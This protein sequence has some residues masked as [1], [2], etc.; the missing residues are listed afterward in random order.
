ML[1]KPP[2]PW[3]PRLAHR[4]PA[5]LLA[6]LCVLGLISFLSHRVPVQFAHYDAG[7]PDSY[8]LYDVQ[9][10]VQTG[11]I[12]RDMTKPPHQPSLYSPLLYMM[13]GLPAR[14]WAFENPFAGPRI[15]VWIALALCIWVCAG[16]AHR[17]VR[18]RAVGW[19]AAGLAFIS[20]IMYVWAGQLRGDFPGILAGLV[21]V[22][23]L[24][25]R[26][27]F[28]VAA[29]GLCAGLATQAKLT[30]VAALGAGLLW[31]ALRRKWRDVVTF[32][33]AGAVG[34][35]GVYGAF[36][37]LEPRMLEHILTLG[38]PVYDPVGLLVILVH[39]A[40]QPLLMLAMCGL[41]PLF[42]R[43][44]VRPRWQ[45]AL[46]YVICSFG[47]AFISAA[48]AGANYNYFYEFLFAFIP[49]A[50]LGAL[51]LLGVARVRP[52]PAA[53]LAGLAVLLFLVQV[54]KE[55]GALF[56]PLNRLTE[57]KERNERL[58]V[59]DEALGEMQ[60]LT[61]VPRLALAQPAP[62]MTEPFL[63]TYLH[64]GQ[65][66]DL[67]FLRAPLR[68]AVFDAVVVYHPL[69]RFRG[70]RVPDRETGHLVDERYQLLCDLDGMRFCAA[71]GRL[72]PESAA[73]RLA[74]VG[75]EAP[76]APGVCIG[77]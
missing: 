57:V 34:S 14:L 73:R 23:L 50:A 40:F 52:I 59:L 32:G 31:L 62:L 74:S 22:R 29:A 75:C 39:L 60:I 70:I 53:L 72:L 41:G 17:L 67:D 49:F 19:W 2:A 42:P 10:W 56:G 33:G 47:T 5:A 35:V 58:A 20:P 26:F 7:Y 43:L 6:A 13:L 25:A 63:L 28:H 51:R 16:L 77:P 66:R 61:F 3:Y 18:V 38:R 15:P 55:P 12:Y 21:A 71:K 54:R 4:V 37:L 11:E 69:F 9:H 48:Q 27:R 24:L 30:Y 8:I 45:L 46:L 64:R 1:Q 65:R 68:E 44:A 36:A 76:M